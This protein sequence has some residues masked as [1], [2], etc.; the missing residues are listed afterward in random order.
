MAKEAFALHTSQQSGR[1]EVEIDGPYDIRR[2][3]LAYSAVGPDEAHDGLFE[4]IEGLYEI[5][6]SLNGQSILPKS[7]AGLQCFRRQQDPYI[8]KHSVFIFVAAADAQQHISGRR[9]VAEPD[10][11]EYL[12]QF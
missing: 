2:Y 4:H 12:L 11:I 3:G 1:H 9:L 6:R 8:V 7:T 5:E 10:V